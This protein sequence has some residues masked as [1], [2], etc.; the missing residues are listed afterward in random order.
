VQRLYDAQLRDAVPLLAASCLLLIVLRR[1]A[2][3]R[4]SASELLVLVSVNVL[5]E[6]TVPNT[7]HDQTLL[8]TV[9]LLV[10]LIG[11]NVLAQSGALA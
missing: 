1:Y 5:V 10:Y 9:L 4:R 8:G 3:Q 6:H 11:F 7:A 2:R